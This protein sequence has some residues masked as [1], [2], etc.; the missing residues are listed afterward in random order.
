M[1]IQG[2]AQLNNLKPY[3]IGQPYISMNANCYID[4][5]NDKAV[6][7]FSALGVDL[8]SDIKY[9][10]GD[11]DSVYGARRVYYVDLN[12]SGQA[13]HRYLV[14]HNLLY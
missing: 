8:F 12:L 2:R 5:N 4:Y 1:Q 13:F 14:K 7:H 6:A 10:R 9:L 3:G 11:D